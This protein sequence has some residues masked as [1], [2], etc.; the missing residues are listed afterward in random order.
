ML[1]VLVGIGIHIS[2]KERKDP[3]IQT[4]GQKERPTAPDKPSKTSGF[5]PVTKSKS[6]AE[7]VSLTRPAIA[8]SPIAIAPAPHEYRWKIPEFGYSSGWQKFGSVDVRI[9]G[10]SITNV[11]L[12]DSKTHVTESDYPM[13]AVFVEVRNNTPNKKRTLLSWT[14][15]GSYYGRIFDT[16]N[17][18]LPPG[19]LPPGSKLHS[20]LPFTQPLPDDGTPVYDILLFRKPD[21]NKGQLDLRLDAERCGESGDIWFTIPSLAWKKKQDEAQKK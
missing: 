11:P 2:T 10:L 19:K 15:S 5:D 20:G 8:Q 1:I 14:S 18:E 7:P 9:A 16:A 17:N 4:E 21:E 12:I 3:V 13:L 6:S